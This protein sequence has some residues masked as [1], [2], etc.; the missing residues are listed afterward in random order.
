VERSLARIFIN[1]SS[2]N[3]DWAI[4]VRD[5]LMENGWDDIFLDLDP[6]RGIAAGER[7]KMALQKAAHRCEVVLALVSPQWLASQWCKTETDAARLMGKRVIV[8]LIGAEK[9]QIPLD[10]TD[11]Q[12]V[13]L[14]NDP[15]GF[16]RLKEGL[17]RIG[18]D[19]ATFPFERGRPAR[20]AREEP[21]RKLNVFISYSRADLAR[22]K[23]IVAAL[24]ARGLACTI[25]TRDLPYGEK[26]QCE[27]KDFIKAADSVVFLVSPR[28]I[29]STWCKWEV[30][31]VADQSKRLVPVVLEP[32]PSR[33]CRRKSARCTCCR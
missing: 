21:G 5:W 29:S 8:A 13:D 28:S 4:R 30:A 20:A 1:H 2:H 32:V 19:P 9:A 17:R 33:S 10:L 12:W 23:E 11:E 3:N 27:L 6:V 18:I 24:E 16:A 7:W 25:D 22:A 31:Q 14:A 15:D 26:W